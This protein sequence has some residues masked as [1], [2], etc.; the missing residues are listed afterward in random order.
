[1]PPPPGQSKRWPTGRYEPVLIRTEP[2]EVKAA[3][4]YESKRNADCT[5]C[6]V[7]TLWCSETIALASLIDSSA[8]SPWETLAEADTPTMPPMAIMQVNDFARRRGSFQFNPDHLYFPHLSH[9]SPLPALL[10][11]SRSPRQPVALGRDVPFLQ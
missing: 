7:S 8:Y 2:P 6:F 3:A 11:Q 4:V 10:E 1:T 9:A 5:E